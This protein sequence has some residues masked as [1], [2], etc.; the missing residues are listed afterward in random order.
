[1]VQ[2]ILAYLVFMYVA[3]LCIAQSVVVVKTATDFSPISGVHVTF[4]HP[5]S[6]TPYPTI[7]NSNGEAQLPDA[8]NQFSKVQFETSY[9]GYSTIRDT[10]SKNQR[11]EITLFWSSID[12][13]QIVVTG[14]LKPGSIE[15]A[16]HA[17]RIIDAK[18]IE[19]QGA[20]NLQDILLKE[21]NIRVSNDNILGS[22]MSMQGISGQNVKILIDGVSVIGRLN[23]QIDLS[24]INLNNI[25]RIEMIEG[26]MSVS[27]GTNALAGT[28]NL[29][30]KKG[31][32]KKWASSGNLYYESV[33]RYNTDVLA[34]ASHNNHSITFSGGR[35]FFDGW[36]PGEVPF[37]YQTEGPADETRF[38]QW[39]LKTQYFGKL[40]YAL[41]KKN[42][43]IS[44]YVEIFDEKIVNKGKPRTGIFQQAFDDTY[45][46]KRQNIGTSYNVKL[47]QFNVNGVTAYNEYNRIAR[48]ETVDLTTLSKLGNDVASN[49]YSFMNRSTIS[50]TKDSSNLHYQ[51]GYDVAHDIAKGERIGK[52]KE[53]M[54][55]V[56]LFTT[57]E[58]KI[59]NDL[60]VRPGLRYSWNSRYDSPL[61]PSLNIKYSF[62]EWQFRASYARGFRAPSIKE[63][64]FNFVDLNHNIQ[65]NENLKAE[66]SNNF[67][68][69]SS[70]KWVSSN[71]IS[72]I[73]MSAFFNQIQDEIGL[74]AVE[75]SEDNEFKYA[76]LGETKSLGLKANFTLTSKNL[77]TTIGVL[78]NGL[79]TPLHGKQGIDEYT[80]NPEIFFTL[81]YVWNRTGLRFNLFSK[82][83]GVREIPRFIGDQIVLSKTYDYTIFDYSVQKSFWKN[84]ITLNVGLKNLFDV[85][86]ILTTRGSSGAHSSSG[87]TSISW[88]RSYFTSLK[89]NFSSKK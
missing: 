51:I 4:Y 27:Y 60:I 36:H 23:D 41:R 86:N 68:V 63:L 28:I 26:P 2:K 8:L 56:A 39:N 34:S 74:Y 54:T 1:M 52:G 64:Y 83:H 48:T 87:S 21:P 45:Y 77:Q 31:G 88:G 80:F 70:K 81:S 37:T 58:Y 71:L 29:I 66:H 62:R 43:D 42:W 46:T 12:M 44:P 14:Q 75:G 85:Q 7:S 89:F 59:I 76:Q 11:K 30:T 5:N 3:N 82:Y 53:N 57:V 61:V 38:Q 49:F 13:N 35:N 17:I 33:G 16:V 73:E 67:Q 20:T 78:A 55:D 19:A 65:G 40:Q 15:K 24:Q 32:A 47:K 79:N 18:Q 50:S 25:E 72:K 84:R 69:Q 6:G 9:I 10:L 22:G